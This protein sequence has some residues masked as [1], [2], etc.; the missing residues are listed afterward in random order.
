MRANIESVLNFI[1]SRDK[2]VIPVYQRNY[3]WEKEHCK[4]LF[5]DIEL[6]YS[7]RLKQYF[8]GSTVVVKGDIGKE[9]IVIDGQQRITS[10]SLIMFAMYNL[11][12]L[13]DIKS[14]NP[15]LAN[16]I[17]KEYL[18]DEYEDKKSWVRL[19]QVNQ[20]AEAYS[21]LYL[22]SDPLHPHAYN[23]NSALKD[24]RVFQ[25]YKYFE[26]RVRA[27]Y[28]K[29][30]NI[31]LLWDAFNKLEIIKIELELSNQ[32]KPQLVFETINATGKS[33][34]DADLIRNYILMDK[35]PDIQEEW[36]QSYWKEIE[37]NT[38]R[39]NEPHT[40]NAIW[41]YLMYKENSYFPYKNT[42]TVFKK[43]IFDISIGKNT[44]DVIE[45]A[46]LELV[47]FTK[48]YKWF[49]DVCQNETF[50]TYFEVF[51]TLKQKTPYAYFMSLMD[52]YDEKQQLDENTV[53]KVLEF[54]SNYYIRRTIIGRPTN[55]YNTMY[56][57]LAN[58]IDGYM[59]HGNDYLESLY[60]VFSNF[61]PR[62]HYPTDQDIE[63]ELPRKDFYNA[64]G[65]R[66]F[67]LQKMC[68]F[69]QKESIVIDDGITVEHIMPQSLTEKWKTELGDNWQEV[70][71]KYL[72][73]IGNLTL[74]GYNSEHSRKLFLQ[75]K[76]LMQEH[77]N[78]PLNKY[79]KKV[80]SWDETQILN[81]AKRM[82]AL[83]NRVFTDIPNR[84]QYKKDYS[85]DY[86]PVEDI[87]DATGTKI[88]SYKI[89]GEIKTPKASSW[90]ILLQSVCKDLQAL[91]ETVN[92]RYFVEDA[93]ALRE[94]Y[95]ISNG[96]Y[97]ETN[98]KQGAEAFKKTLINILYDFDCVGELA[99][100]LE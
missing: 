15:N 26:T 78:I 1:G 4:R 80:T 87:G 48:Y 33:L 45:N 25:N 34:D 49:N 41:H 79:F 95:E 42:Y 84:A 27:F 39:D 94:P 30:G 83:F 71:E 52:A 98:S 96:L 10:L 56:P 14:E 44:L 22:L 68:N 54:I 59:S 99:L 57:T 92:C 100:K 3:A 97:V 61:I 64:K 85:T 63:L 29:H 12:K 82:I 18:V 24:T 66:S 75:K 58:R 51:R 28:K 2:F 43:F 6:I 88:H 81:N 55:P 74:T 91:D 46:L 11:L 67:V 21:N 93:D 23:K 37:F 32:D 40:L 86:I 35:E 19:K 90:K 5:D 13:K 20:D 72:H 53:C 17:F 8:L 38:H 60:Y 89:L 9:F 77:S 65:I 73:T 36:Y 31:D 70:H 16:I 76:E 62:D 7:N 47:R 50:E 69:D